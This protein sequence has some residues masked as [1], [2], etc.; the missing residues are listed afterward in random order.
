MKKFAVLTVLALM[1]ASCAT[2][3]PQPN[4]PPEIRTIAVPVF[5]NS[6]NTFNIEQYITQKTVD[7]FIT[8]GRVSVMDEF[9]ADAVAKCTITRYILTPIVF[10][11]KQTPVQYRLRVYVD[12]SM[13]DNKAQAEMYKQKDIWEETTYF[14]VNNMGMPAETEELART[15]VL[16]QL[17]GRIVRRV[18]YGSMN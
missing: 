5:I 17:A 16:D 14:V 18:V 1:L 4:L 3:A 11:E 6:T 10:D 7:G 9:R 12:I 8:D 15:R 13:F 2:Y